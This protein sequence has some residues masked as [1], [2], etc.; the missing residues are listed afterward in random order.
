MANVRSFDMKNYFKIL[1]ISIFLNIFFI[2]TSFADYNWKKLGSNIDGE[3]FYIDT[4]SIKGNGNKVFYFYMNDYAKPDKFGDLSSRAYME[5]NCLNLDYRFLKDFY[6]QEP[7]GNGKPSSIYDKVGK[8]EV[9]GKGS[10]G[11]V[12]RK[13]ACNYK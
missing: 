12:I 11:E 7:M 10:I 3:V 5:V 8:W 13:F 6:Y 9:T 1:I 2:T 4:P